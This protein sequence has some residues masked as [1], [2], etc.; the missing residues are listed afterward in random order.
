LLEGVREGYMERSIVGVGGEY[1][2]RGGN[3]EVEGTCSKRELRLNFR[4][5]AGVC[6]TLPL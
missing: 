1:R 2:G 5:S 3:G 6:Q 4:W